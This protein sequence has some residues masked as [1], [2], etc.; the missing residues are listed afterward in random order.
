M[1]L[2]FYLPAPSQSIAHLTLL[3]AAIERLT[4]LA[5]LLAHPLTV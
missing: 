4:L 2:L 3:Y 1:A 5:A